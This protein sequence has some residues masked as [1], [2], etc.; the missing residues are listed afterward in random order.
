MFDPVKLFQ[1]IATAN[2]LGFAYGR[3]DFQNWAMTREEKLDDFEVILGL[4][5]FEEYANMD[6]G[7]VSDWEAS[8][9]FWVGRKFDIG[10]ITFSSMD[11]TEQQKYDRRLKYLRGY[12][13]TI[14][15]NLCDDA[16]VEVIGRPHVSRELN[17][18][19]ENVDCVL[20]EIT[21][22]YDMNHTN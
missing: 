13:D 6:N 2:N 8:T 9:I 18:F 12:I 1:D 17:K 16:F 14:L 22:R 21:F 5:P 20:C 7:S 4:M 19:D 10:E 3:K 11:E 15:G